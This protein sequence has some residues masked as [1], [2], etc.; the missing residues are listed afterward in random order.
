MYIDHNS[1]IREIFSQV[2]EV[3]QHGLDELF[4]DEVRQGSK[5]FADEIVRAGIATKEDILGIVGQYLNCEVQI[6]QVE[7]IEGEVLALI[8]GDVAR[9]YAVVPL[10]ISEDGIHLLASDPFNSAIIDDLTF[11]LNLDILL[12]VCDP[13]EVD[14]LIENLVY[15]N[16][17]HH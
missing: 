15:A 6:G 9:Q 10:Y 1:T 5:S 7:E 14:R 12:I 2:A 13:E 16:L 17:Y 8:P 11:S 4:D 3:S